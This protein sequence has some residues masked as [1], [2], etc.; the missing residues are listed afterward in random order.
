MT[1][2]TRVTRELFKVSATVRAAVAER[3]IQAKRDSLHFLA[4]IC[5]LGPFLLHIGTQTI[6][7]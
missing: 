1:S 4:F 2:F 6:I 5:P 7:S 3:A